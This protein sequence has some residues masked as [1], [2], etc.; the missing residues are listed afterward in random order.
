MKL[1]LANDPLRMAGATAFFS[2][3]ALPAILLIVTQIFGLLLNRRDLSRGIIA[4]LS[5]ILGQN[6]ARQVAL[7]WRG[8]RGLGSSLP[9]AIFGFIFM[10]FVATTLFKIIK[11]SLH[12]LWMI[13]GPEKSTFM[14]GLSGRLRSLCV[15]LIAGVLF[16]ASLVAESFRVILD[17]F[18]QENVPSAALFFNEFITQVFALVIVTTWFTILFRYL[19][20]GKPSWK[21]AFAGGLV[22]GMLFNFGKVVLRWALESSNLGLLYGASASIVLLLLF[23]FYSAIMLYYGAAFTRVWSAYRQHPIQPM[24]NSMFYELAE[25][26]ADK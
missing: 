7:T 22:T 2:T 11:G 12:Q 15:I 26:K 4:R 5:E 25:I 8:F 1:L 21:A 16:L 13:K 17:T 9:A 24:R 23:V 19:A 6:S 20:D 3:F 10:I 18:L 14:S